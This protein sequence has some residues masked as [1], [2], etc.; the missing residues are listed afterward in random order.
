MHD[1]YVLQ[2]RVDLLISGKQGVEVF[3]FKTGARVEPDSPWFRVYQQ[4]LY[5]YAC[6]LHQSQS[7]YPER[8]T[9]YW[10]AEERQEDALVEIDFAPED[11][12]QIKE[13]LHETITQIRQKQFAV[14]VPPPP[15]ICQTCDARSLC[16]KEQII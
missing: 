9:L 3:D 1:D 5:F 15:M 14:K 6:A 12:A 7:A 11:L 16:K 8:L 4:Q 10:T 2:G 13:T